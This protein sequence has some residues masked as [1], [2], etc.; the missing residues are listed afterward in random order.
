MAAKLMLMSPDE[1]CSLTF[2]RTVEQLK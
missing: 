2:G 1:L